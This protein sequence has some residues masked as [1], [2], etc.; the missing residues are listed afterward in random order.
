VLME[1]PFRPGQRVR[2]NCPVFHKSDATNRVARVGHRLVDGRILSRQAGRMDPLCE[3]WVESPTPRPARDALGSYM[4]DIGTSVVLAHESELT[5]VVLPLP[6]TARRTCQECDAMV[7]EGQSLCAA[8]A[9]K[10]R[11]AMGC[12]LDST[13]TEKVAQ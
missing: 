10:P 3:R 13:P 9:A 1:H 5:I 8:C 2:F 7:L 4:V 12:V 6:S 11:D